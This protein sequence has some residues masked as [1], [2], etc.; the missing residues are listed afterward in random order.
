VAFCAENERGIKFIQGMVGVK[1]QEQILGGL[2]EE[3]AFHTIATFA[4]P[5]I[6]NASPATLCP[7]SPL[8]VPK[9][10]LTHMQI[11]WIT[12]SPVKVIR[13]FDKFRSATPPCK[14]T[15]NSSTGGGPPFRQS[16][17]TVPKSG[18]QKVR[19]CSFINL[20]HQRQQA[21]VKGAQ[22]VKP[23]SFS[24]SRE[25]IPLDIMRVNILI[26]PIKMSLD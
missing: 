14:T 6:L 4:G 2:A 20:T 7:A 18:S 12:G 17:I 26:T 24:S 10:H 5:H 16:R 22:A 1:K 23:E 19:F 21:R 13:R 11:P 8:D 25:Q 3:K 9:C 15:F